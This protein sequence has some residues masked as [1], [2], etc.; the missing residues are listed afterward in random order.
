MPPCRLNRLHRWRRTSSDGKPF[1]ISGHPNSDGR[2]VAGD[3]RQRQSRFRIDN[4]IAAWH[5]RAPSYCGPSWLR[6][7]HISRL[8]L[9]PP[10]CCVR[11]QSE[12]FP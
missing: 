8:S 4:V 9:G 12:G 11:V 7:Y 2:F 3:S 1:E 10:Q 5:L 6:G